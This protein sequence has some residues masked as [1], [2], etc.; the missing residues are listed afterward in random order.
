MIFKKN[1]AIMKITLAA[2]KPAKKELN[3]GIPITIKPFGN[4]GNVKT[5]CLEGSIIWKNNFPCHETADDNCKYVIMQKLC[6]EIPVSFGVN[7][8]TDNPFIDCECSYEDCDSVNDDEKEIITD[9]DWIKLI[10]NI[11]LLT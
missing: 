7:V 4:I 1:T 2:L 6:V 3:V 8:E 9:F 11:L 5:T 10:F